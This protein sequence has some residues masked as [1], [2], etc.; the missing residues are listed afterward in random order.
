MTYLKCCLTNLSC[1]LT[2]DG[3]KKSLLCCK[4]CL[5]LWCNL[6]YK[7]IT[8]TNLCTYT[9]DTSLIKVLECVIADTRDIT[10]NLLRSELCIT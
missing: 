5:T 7:D 3:T 8:G 1:L 4:L 2:K 10:C 6:S 9:D